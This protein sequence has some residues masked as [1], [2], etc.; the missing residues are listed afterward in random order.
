MVAE[1]ELWAARGGAA[2]EDTYRT[3]IEAV[4]MIV[5]KVRCNNY[6]FIFDQAR[7]AT[8]RYGVMSISLLALKTRP[9]GVRRPG[10]RFSSVHGHCSQRVIAVAAMTSP[11]ST[12]SSVA[13][14]CSRAPTWR[15]KSRRAAGATAANL[16][17]VMPSAVCWATNASRLGW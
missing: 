3:L 12:K 9:R 7:V 2:H 16:L 10:S 5:R 4:G 13:R 8:T 15:R 6:T 11:R 17:P 14:F 1:A